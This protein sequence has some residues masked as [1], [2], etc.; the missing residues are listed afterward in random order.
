MNTVK[1]RKK[2]FGLSKTLAV[3]IIIIVVMLLGFAYLQVKGLSNAVTN[4]GNTIDENQKQIDLLKSVIDELNKELDAATKPERDKQEAKKQRSIFIQNEIKCLADNAYHEAAYEPEIGQLGVM[5]V[6]MN[7]VAEPGYPKSACGVVHEAHYVSKLQKTICQFT[8]YCLNS[9]EV[10]HPSIY[11]PLYAMAKAVYYRHERAD[12][13]GDAT[14][15]HAVYV[16]PKWAD[17]VQMIAQV[18]NHVFY[19]DKE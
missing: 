1:R 3:N 12:V 17:G 18:G 2:K 16:K 19:K 6:V 10:I 13:V 7:R 11:K 14:L 5:T 4:L 9:K 15:Y 8:W